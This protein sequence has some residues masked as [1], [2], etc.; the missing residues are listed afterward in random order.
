MQERLRALRNERGWTQQHLAA[1][2][3]VPDA[4]ISRIERG[5]TTD[6]SINIV[7]RLANSFDVTLDYL[8]GVSDLPRGC[9]G[10]AS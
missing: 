6:I 10:G 7:R 5:E 1:L 9:M 2:S 4:T 8:A 3:G